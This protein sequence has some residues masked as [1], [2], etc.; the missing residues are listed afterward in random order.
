MNKNKKINKAK[1]L[2]KKNISQVK[3]SK[4]KEKTLK[5]NKSKKV[6][7]NSYKTSPTPDLSIENKKN[8]SLN[9]E[10]LKNIFDVNKKFN[11]KIIKI[12]SKKINTSQ[13][14]FSSDN[15]PQKKIPKSKSPQNNPKKKLTNNKIINFI[16]WSKVN[17]S[18]DGDLLNLKNS[19]ELDLSKIN[20]NNFRSLFK[21]LKNNN[22][23]SDE[24]PLTYA[25]KRIERY[26]L[27]RRNNNTFN[28]HIL[29]NVD[30]NNKKNISLGRNQDNKTRH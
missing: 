10:I 1:P 5:N 4:N 30:M 25:K 24:C 7:K 22:L 9:A 3:V 2:S 29:S 23:K 12:V 11:K 19:I 20:A 18:S 27:N 15:S 26:I 16:D 17:V 13:N 6:L 28:R 8:K 14:N 21:K